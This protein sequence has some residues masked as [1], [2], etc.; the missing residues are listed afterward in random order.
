MK[1][2][3]LL[4]Y[5]AT[6]AV[7]FSTLVVMLLLILAVQGI[8][9]GLSSTFISEKTPVR[10]Y[11]DQDPNW[12]IPSSVTGFLPDGTIH[13]ICRTGYGKAGEQYNT[14]QIYD[15]N[16]KLLWQG[17]H[18]DRPYKYLTWAMYPT[19]SIGEGWMR[20]MGMITP[21]FSRVI[22]IPVSSQERTLEAWRYESQSQHFVGY[23]IKGD[24]IGYIGASGFTQS[25][26]ETTPFGK[27]KLCTGWVP[28]NSFSPTLLWQ[29][30]RRI[31]QINF[32]ERKVSLLFESTGG[33]IKSIALQNWN[34]FDMSKTQDANNEYRPMM[35][36]SIGDNGKYHLM[37]RDPQQELTVNVPHPKQGAH[38]TATKEA[39][40]FNQSVSDANP[41][42]TYEQSPKLWSKYWEDYQKKPH[43]N[44]IELY[45]VENDG[46]VSL[47]NSFEW[48]RPVEHS[49]ARSDLNWLTKQYLTVVSPPFY[50]VAWHW[51]MNHRIARSSGMEDNAVTY[52]F[53]QILEWWR[54]AYRYANWAL[55]IVLMALMLWHG[56]PRRTSWAK[57]F[58]WIIFTG[59]FGV[60]GFLTYWALNHT[61]IIKC[62]LCGKYRGLGRLDCVRCGAE[63]PEPQHG[64]L[65]LILNP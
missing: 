9:Y 25:K 45:K 1:L 47:A 54:P 22:E 52:V 12:R 36:I 29:T 4:K 59:L 17:L 18:K 49:I 24:K 38:F 62:P 16:D 39:I 58:F 34:A 31:Y 64:K 23:E 41:P 8:F 7:V 2:K 14:E 5:I 6:P 27:F 44:G 46:R 56:W 51:G 40:F 19:Q 37:L 30:D 11:K 26:A 13:L 65:D 50:A 28:Q 43:K 60:A 10:S 33:D 63:L 53:W 35:C 55:S 57:L 32:E 42:V 61:A 20:E 48:I 3:D 15:V 21:E